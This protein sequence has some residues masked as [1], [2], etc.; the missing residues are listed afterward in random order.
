MLLC[1]AIVYFSYVGMETTYKEARASVIAWAKV[2]PESLVETNDEQTFAMASAM[3]PK[4][5]AV[6]LPVVGGIND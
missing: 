4:L 2:Q 3:P 6:K 5:D 1:G